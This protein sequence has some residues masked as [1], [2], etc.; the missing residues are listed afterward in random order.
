MPAIQEFCDIFCLDS[1]GLSRKEKLILEADLFVQVCR[2]LIEIFRQY[3]QNYFI[4]MNFSVEMENAMLEENFLQLLIKDILI[5]GE[6]TVAGIAH[7]TNI[8][9]DIVHEVLIGRNNC[10]SAAFLRRTIELHQSVRRDIY[11]QIRKKIA[12]N[13]LSAA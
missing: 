1:Q 9:E 8:H 7:Y 2:E 11:Q 12:D 10:P 3:F 5:S 4:L 13:Y 6:Y